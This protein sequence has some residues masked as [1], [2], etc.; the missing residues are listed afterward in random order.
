MKITIKI[1]EALFRRAKLFAGKRGIS[2]REL[3]AEALTESLARAGTQDKP[4][5]NTFGKLQ[6]LHAE[7]VRINRIIE[8]EFGQSEA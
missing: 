8:S 5:M 4:W 3:V 2:L 6:D 1:P 7:T